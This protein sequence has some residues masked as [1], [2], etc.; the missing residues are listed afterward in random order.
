MRERCDHYYDNQLIIS[1]HTK[2]RSDKYGGYLQAF[3]AQILK[4]AGKDIQYLY[5]LGV[6]VTD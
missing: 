6:Q 5:E 3:D 4:A 1:D 2:G